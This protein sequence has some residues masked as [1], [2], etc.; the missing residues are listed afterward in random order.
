MS[1]LIT[2]CNGLVG[3][4]LSRLLQ[5]NGVRVFGTSLNGL[6]N[7]Y[8]APADY[9]RAD[10]RDEN[11]VGEVFAKFSPSVVVHAAALTK[12]DAC[13]AD[14]VANQSINLDAVKTVCR[15]AERNNAHVVHLSTDFVFAGTHAEHAEDSNDF[16]PVN[17]YGWAKYG[18]ERYV[19]EHHPQAAIVRTALVYGYEPLLPRNN[20]FTWAVDRLRQGEH[21]RVVD[22]QFRTPTFADDLARGLFALCDK[23]SAGVFHLAGPDFM[24]VYDFV[25]YTAD[26]FGLDKTWVTPV[27]TRSLNEPALRPPCTRLLIDK[28]CR[29]LGYAPHDLHT[30]LQ[31]LLK[32]YP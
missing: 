16:P 4:R 31:L 29:E 23:K 8:I 13:A 22:D 3:C 7:P 12:P 21:I 28:A 18:A 9:L 11:A 2:G 5:N 10:I 15:T 27:S 20:I 30:N 1:V 17:I 19:R 26:V 6:T 14:P 24:N 25:C 32:E